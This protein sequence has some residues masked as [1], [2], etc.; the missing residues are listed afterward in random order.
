MVKKDDK[1]AARAWSE[2]LGRRG[3]NPMYATRKVSVPAV[4][5]DLEE[6]GMM[7]TNDA[8]IWSISAIFL[9]GMIGDKVPDVSTLTAPAGG[10]RGMFGGFGFGA[11]A[12]ETQEAPKPQA[13]ALPEIGAPAPRSGSGRN[14][15]R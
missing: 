6:N 1:L 2:L 5:N 10:G 13:P 15:N 4:L 9:P 12:Q 8:A 14:A 7:S 11:P 3:L